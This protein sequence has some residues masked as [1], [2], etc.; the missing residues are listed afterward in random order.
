MTIWP[1]EVVCAFVTPG[2]LA[3]AVGEPALVRVSVQVPPLSI[4]FGR[5][6]VPISFLAASSQV[7]LCRVTG[8]IGR[9]S[10]SVADGVGDGAVPGACSAG[11]ETLGEA[12]GSAGVALALTVG[13]TLALGVAAG[14]PDVQPVTPAMTKAPRTANMRVV[15]ETTRTT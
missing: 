8:V 1:Q 2:T 15:F 5:N 13:E 14:G 7:T 4:T 11:A 12:D 3:E 9:V 6:P 10:V